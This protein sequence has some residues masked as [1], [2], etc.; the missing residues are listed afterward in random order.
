VSPPASVRNPPTDGEPVVCGDWSVRIGG[1]VSVAGGPWSVRPQST[2]PHRPPMPGLPA[3][4]RLAG[5]CRGRKKRAAAK[6][7]IASSRGGLPTSGSSPGAS[8]MNRR[9]CHLLAPAL[10]RRACSCR[11]RPS[12]FPSGRRVA[13]TF[14]GRSVAVAS[15][16]EPVDG[17]YRSVAW[18]PHVGRVLRLAFQVRAP[19]RCSLPRALPAAGP[20]V[21]ALT[22]RKVSL[23]NVQRP[24]PVR[25][26]R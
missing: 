11:L 23:C 19:S 18:D 9:P 14:P 12:P 17:S 13:C 4:H 16:A 20:C 21:P 5:P 6:S 10:C 3:A 8:P 2:D 7:A 25:P 1:R 22:L 24:D 26:P 15:A